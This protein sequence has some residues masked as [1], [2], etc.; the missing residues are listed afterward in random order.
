MT[1]ADPVEAARKQVEELKTKGVDVIVALAHVGIDES[2]EVVST[3]IADEVDGIDVIVD[4]HSHSTLQ[5]G[6]ITEN[7]TLIASTGEYQNNLGKVVI[8]VDG[9]SKKI[10]TKKASLI[11]KAETTDI[12]GNKTVLDKIKDIDAEQSEFLSKVIGNSKVHLEGAR[13]YS[14]TQETNLGN[15]ITDAMLDETGAEIAITNGGG[16]RDS[17]DEGEITK[18]E[19]VKV[20]PFGNYIVTKAL[21]GAQIKEVLE[22]G[23]KAYPAPAGHFPH[24]SG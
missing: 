7:G 13:E 6:I 2:S 12:E 3:M 4:G 16:I 18:G 24:V 21:T 9:E 8:T 23:I 20:L 1:F 5:E 10:V 19:I 17:I 22:H 15:L 14:R 11:S